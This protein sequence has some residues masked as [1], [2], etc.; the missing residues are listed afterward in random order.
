MGRFIHDVPVGG[1]AS[2]R[3]ETSRHV[4]R[5]VCA[6]ACVPLK[7]PAS[8]P[9]LRHH[10]LR[11]ALLLWFSHSASRTRAT[12]HAHDTRSTKRSGERC[13]APSQ[14]DKTTR[15]NA[16]Q[17]NTQ[18]TAGWL[19]EGVSRQRAEVPTVDSPASCR[20]AAASGWTFA[21]PLPHGP[22]PSS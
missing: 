22:P 13:A 7:P 18:R 4:A 6:R 2:G 10:F 3:R 11:D 15:R 14:R 19:P 12:Q 5:C 21:P 1:R 8:E 16:T 20:D 9:C 17:L